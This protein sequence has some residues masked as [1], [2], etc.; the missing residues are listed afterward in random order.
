MCSFF[1]HEHHDFPICFDART[2][3][4]DCGIL[5]GRASA[6]IGRRWK[7][8][9]QIYKQILALKEFSQSIFCSEEGFKVRTAVTLFTVNDPC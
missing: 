4:L 7:T 2:A 1:G 9:R 3:R 5:Y 8:S 6:A